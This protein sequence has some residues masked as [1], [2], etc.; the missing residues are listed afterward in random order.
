MFV[1]VSQPRLLFVYSRLFACHEPVQRTFGRELWLNDGSCNSFAGVMDIRGW[2]P[3]PLLTS[4]K[5]CSI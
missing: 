3:Q 5:I 2:E 4:H 1:F